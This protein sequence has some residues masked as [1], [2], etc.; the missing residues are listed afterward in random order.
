MG[1]TGEKFN[2]GEGSRQLIIPAE[3]KAKNTLDL[4]NKL[5]P[6]DLQAVVANLRPDSKQYF[7][8]FRN[9]ILN[10]SYL[11]DRLKSLEL[12]RLIA[13]NIRNDPKLINKTPFDAVRYKDY[14]GEIA[15]AVPEFTEIKTPWGVDLSP[16]RSVNKNK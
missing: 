8:R 9:H 13:A 4:T 14:T 2:F 1:I 7:K 6:D 11:S 10:Q 5:E 15:W 12:N 16:I 3:I